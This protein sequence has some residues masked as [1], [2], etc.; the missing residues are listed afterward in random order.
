MQRRFLFLHLLVLGAAFT[1]CSPKFYRNSA[2]KETYKVIQQKQKAALGKTNEFSIDTSFSNRDPKSITSA[3]IIQGRTNSFFL[4]LSLED[5]LSMAMTNSRNFQL[6]KESLYLL[7]LGLTHDRYQYTPIFDLSARADETRFSTKDQ[8]VGVHPEGGFTQ[9]FKGGGR[10]SVQILNDFLQYYTGDPRRSAL[11][12]ISANLTQPLL[13][14]SSAKIVAEQLTQSE[15]DVI[16]EIRNFAR[17]QNTFSVGIITTYYRLVQQKD[18]VRNEYNNYQILVKGIDRAENLSFD[19]LPAFQ[20]DQ[21]RQDE[22]AAK[23]RYI[24]AVQDYQNKIDSF[25]MDLGLPQGVDLLLDDAPLEDLTVAGLLGVPISEEEGFQMSI[26]HRLDLLNEIDRFEDAK[27]KIDVAKDALRTQLDFVA[28]ASLGSDRPNDY[29]H[30]DLDKYQASAGFKLNL[31]INRLPER[32]NYR[33]SLINFE[34]ELRTLAIALDN[35]K[36]DIRNGLR[37][38]GQ[39]RQ[40]YEIQRVAAELANRR[41]E[42]ADLLLQAGRAQIRDLLDAQASLL[43]ARNSVSSALVEYHS[44]RLNLLINLEVLDASKPRFWLAEVKGLGAGPSPVV[45]HEKEVIP[46]DKLF[47]KKS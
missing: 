20:V 13:R 21:A 15:R 17:F 29:S 5:A 7:A 43:Q 42:S 26:L 9:V 37:T 38:L 47:G 46:P 30:F 31:P 25:K 28:D 35:A 1:A 40:N 3:E 11:S 27:R 19:R 4:R 2:D 22:L 39:A 45:E 33:S 23:T 10:L 34:R 18:V 6:R 24:L 16:Y 36:S 8:Q 41:V 32:N 12:T 14:G 44:A